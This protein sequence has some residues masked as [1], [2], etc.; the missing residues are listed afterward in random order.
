MK[1]ASMGERETDLG[2]RPVGLGGMAKDVNKV[3]KEPSSGKS[4]R[5]GWRESTTVLVLYMASLGSIPSPR[6]P[7]RSN[8]QAQRQE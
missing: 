7:T 6:N 1:T 5:W 4:L 3:I 8:P 2:M